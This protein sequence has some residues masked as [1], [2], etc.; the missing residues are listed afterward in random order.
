MIG[1]P[2]LGEP[3]VR[4]LAALVF[5]V[6]RSARWSSG[7]L[8]RGAATKPAGLL[9]RSKSDLPAVRVVGKP[10]TW[11]TICKDDH[12]NRYTLND[13]PRDRPTE[14]IGTGCWPRADDEAI[15]GL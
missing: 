2:P 4:V 12:G 13:L 3:R 15:G 5:L 1:S 10:L 11:A 8:D 6:R 7:R 9:R 14:R